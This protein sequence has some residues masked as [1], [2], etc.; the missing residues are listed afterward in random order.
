MGL[1]AGS[2]VGALA[3]MAPVEIAAWRLRSP[4]FHIGRIALEAEQLYAVLDGLP[5]GVFAMTLD[6]RVVYW[7]RGARELL[8]YAPSAVVGQRCAD[9][10]SGLDRYGLTSDCGEG[11]VCLRSARVGMVPSPSLLEMRCSWG[12]LKMV[13]VTPLALA[14]VGPLGRVLVYLLDV[15]EREGVEARPGWVMAARTGEAGYAGDVILTPREMDVLR[16]VALGWRN[17]YIADEL[18]VTL[19]TVRAHV[20]NV[21]HK[22]DADSRYGAVMAALRLGILELR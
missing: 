20:T 9:I 7:G 10:P 21:R 5:W 4:C 11:C 1:G 14:S 22:L 19:N 3:R 2:P 12:E 13:D 18:G 17:E 8:G 15:S 16:L 6:Q